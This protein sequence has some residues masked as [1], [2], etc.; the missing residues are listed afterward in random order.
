MKVSYPPG[1]EPGGEPEADP[2]TRF[3]NW[4]G[5]LIA[6]IA[7]NALFVYGMWGS[8]S[9]PGLSAWIKALSWFPFNVIATVL[10]YVF[11]VKLGKA[12]GATGGGLYIV[13][14]LALI[15]ANWI[16]MFAA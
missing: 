15:A 16:A 14:C 5:F 4:R 8:T 12:E 6:A 1:Q 2:L 10:Y 11:M 13:L 7:V 3:R 9:E